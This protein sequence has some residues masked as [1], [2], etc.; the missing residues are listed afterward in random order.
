M[1]RAWLQEIVDENIS[2][3]QKVLDFKKL[4]AVHDSSC[5]WSDER[6][7]D[8]NKRTD[9]GTGSVNTNANN[10]GGNHREQVVTGTH[11]KS[12]SSTQNG[13]TSNAVLRRPPGLSGRAEAQ[14]TTSSGSNYSTTTDAGV[15]GDNRIIIDSPQE[16]TRNATFCIYSGELIS[17]ASNYTV[18]LCCVDFLRNSLLGFLRRSDTFLHCS[19]E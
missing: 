3:D 15:R 6:K 7:S 10:D 4:G 19:S 2:N 17:T 18:Y 16:R 8:R 9:A 12:N 14:P 1:Y 13:S 5:N 11:M